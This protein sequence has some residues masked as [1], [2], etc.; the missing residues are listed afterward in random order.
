MKGNGTKGIRMSD[1]TLDKIFSI[2]RIRRRSYEY[3]PFIGEWLYRRRTPVPVIDKFVFP[4]LRTV[5]TPIDDSM[6]SEQQMSSCE[7]SLFIWEYRR[8]GRIVRFFR[9]LYDGFR[10]RGGGCFS[11]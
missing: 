4:V 8:T 3:F 5:P 9:K 7:N 10:R 2:K 1:L 11:V 6:W